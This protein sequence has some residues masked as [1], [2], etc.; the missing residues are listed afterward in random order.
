MPLES[1]DSLEYLHYKIQRKEVLSMKLLVGLDVS[2]QKLDVCMLQS[3][4]KVL[5]QTTVDNNLFGADLIKNNILTYTNSCDYESIEIGLESTSVYSFHPAMFFYEDNTLKT[6]NTHIHV[7]NPK[8]VHKFKA[9]FDEDKTDKMDAYRIADYLRGEF[10][11]TNLIKSEQY[12][13]LQK[14]T[15]TRHQLIKQLV[16]SKQHFIENLYYKC[17]TLSAEIDTNIFGTTMMEII[18]DEDGMDAFA[19]MPLKDLKAFL[20]EKSKGRFSN[21]ESLAKAIQ[22]AIRNSYRLGEILS[23]SVDLILGTYANIIRTLQKQIKI[24]DKSISDVFSSLPEAQSLLSIP[25]IGPV[26]AAGI[27]AEV[28]Q[29]ER[30]DDQA[31]LAKYAGLSW[32]KYQSGTFTAEKTSMRRTGNQYLRYYL[33]EAANSVRMHIPEYRKYY[34][35]KAA[36]VPKFKHK[37][38]LVLTARKFVRLVDAL[39]RTHQLYSPERECAKI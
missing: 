33:V 14:L 27:L 1:R 37:R 9:M 22:K 35:K 34:A 18:T 25:G 39:L 5:C 24:L 10:H 6:M 16:A 2:S 23:G 15:R 17:N 32:S 13:A 19:E 29:I 26:F 4:K 28:G 31:K 3:D 38:A 36:E 21:P 11:T 30:F 7:I 8:R 12:V 20:I